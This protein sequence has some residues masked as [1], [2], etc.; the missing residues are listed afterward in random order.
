MSDTPTVIVAASDAT[1]EGKAAAD[2]ICDGVNDS[3][4]IRHAFQ[5]LEDQG[6]GV[7]KL[8][9]GHFDWSSHGG[10]TMNDKPIRVEVL[11]FGVKQ[12]DQRY[13][14]FEDAAVAAAYACDLNTAWYGTATNVETGEEWSRKKLLEYGFERMDGNDD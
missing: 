6:G 4:E 13:E 9:G 1:P 7:L 8:M 14:S 11:R 12:P 10:N 5:L 3:V 2:F